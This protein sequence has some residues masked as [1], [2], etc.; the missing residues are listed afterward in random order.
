MADT[1]LKLMEQRCSV[2]LFADK[3]VEEEKLDYLLNAARIAPS[4]VNL[5]PWTF[6]VVQSEEAKND[7]RGCYDREWFRSAPLYIVVCGNHETSWKRPS[8]K[9][10]HCDIDVAIATEHIALAATEVGLG[11]CWVCNFDAV[12]CKKVLYLPD[13][14]EPVVILPVGYP[15]EEFNRVEK[16]RK[17]ADEVVLYL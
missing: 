10:D 6:I 14:I 16:K 2:R 9:K 7:I 5:Q 1:L 13:H 8:D 12:K 15:S 3:E 17:T 11:S 4:A